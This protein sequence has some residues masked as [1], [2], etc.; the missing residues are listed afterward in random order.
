M[1]GPHGLD[2]R[3]LAGPHGLEASFLGVQGV[4]C[5]ELVG[6]LGVSADAIGAADKPA[7]A[8]AKAATV[9]FLDIEFPLVN[10]LRLRRYGAA[11]FLLHPSAP[12]IDCNCSDDHDDID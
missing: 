1:D 11:K 4:F 5:S 3:F 9:D 10:E 6:F 8:K 7:K 12:N 2:A